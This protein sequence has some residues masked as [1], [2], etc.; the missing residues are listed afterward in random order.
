[1]FLNEN[2][3]NTHNSEVSKIKLNNITL[4]YTK[5]SLVVLILSAIPLQIAVAALYEISTHS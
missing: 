3:M 5:A 4:S 1:M 2:E